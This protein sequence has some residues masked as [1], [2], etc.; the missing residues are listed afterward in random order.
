MA[1]RELHA[2]GRRRTSRQVAGDSAERAVAVALVAAGWIILARNVRVGRDEVDLVALDPGDPPTLVMVEV[3][4]RTRP[5][6]VAAGDSGYGVPEESVD[7]RKVARLYRAALALLRDGRLP[8]G[9]PLPAVPWRVDLVTAV[10]D[11]PTG[12]WLLGTHVRGL[13]PP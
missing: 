11:S 10:R 4:S 8:D 3:R 13:E 5:G 9:Q 6:S 12:A 2:G 7:G 1:G